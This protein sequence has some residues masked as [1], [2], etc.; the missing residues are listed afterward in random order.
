MTY[1]GHIE[2]GVAV[3]DE[4]VNLK[5]GTRVRIEVAEDDEQPTGRTL[6][7]RLAPIIG[8]AYTPV[9]KRCTLA[10]A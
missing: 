6:A 8:K 1:N 3:L 5:D 4:A 2:N 10:V 9:I 7:E